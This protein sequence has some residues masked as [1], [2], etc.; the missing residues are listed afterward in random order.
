M[1]CLRVRAGR[2]RQKVCKLV[3]LIRAVVISCLIHRPLPLRA[4]GCYLN[5]HYSLTNERWHVVQEPNRT[6]SHISCCVFCSFPRSL[7]PSAHLRVSCH[8]GVVAVVVQRGRGRV[9]VARSIRITADPVVLAP[10]GDLLAIFEPV[11][12]WNKRRKALRCWQ[13]SFSKFYPSII[14]TT[15]PFEGHRSDIRRDAGYTLDWLPVY[16]R[17]TIQRPATIYIYGQFRVSS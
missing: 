3:T 14:Y 15:Y 2:G 8:D 12:L 5:T 1:K 7:Y 11:D 17:V 16:H 13:F 10:L 4:R 9:Q 6:F